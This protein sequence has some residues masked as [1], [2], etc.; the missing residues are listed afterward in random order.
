MIA[1]EHDRIFADPVQSPADFVF[2]ERVAAVFPDMLR[3][4]IPGYATIIQMIGLLA[5]GQLPPTGQC[6]DLGCSLGAAAL[7]IQRAAPGR[8]VVGVD[9]SLAMLAKARNTLSKEAPEIELVEADVQDFPL[10]PAALVVLN[11]TLQFL[12]LSGRKAVLERIYQALVPGGVLVLSEKIAFDHSV[13]NDRFIELHQAFKKAQGYS[14]LEISQKRTALERVLLPE[15]L[16]AHEE[17]LSEVGFTLVRPWFQC[18][19]FV[20]LLAIKA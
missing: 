9:N 15:Q 8:R 7:A 14:E 6:Y 11:F 18:F 4:S 13:M 19:N 17:R 12:P 1:V 5:A 10:Q 20:S 3:R 16:R 2:D